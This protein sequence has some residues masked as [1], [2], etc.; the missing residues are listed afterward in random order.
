MT[1]KNIN[2]FSLADKTKLVAPDGTAL[3][4]AQILEK[5]TPFLEDMPTMEGNLATGHMGALQTELASSTFTD[6]YEGVIPTKGKNQIITWTTARQRSLAVVDADLLKL[7]NNSDI[8]LMN[9]SLSHLMGMGQDWESK[10]IYGTKDDSGRILGL[11]AT[12]DHLSTSETDIGSNVI[13]AGGTGS[14]NSSIWL[15]Y[16]GMNNAHGIY[17][18]GSVG[19]IEK[20]D[21]KT[22][23]VTAPNGVGQYEARRIL[24]KHDCGLAIPNWKSI[25]RIA[26]IDVSELAD[27]GESTYD[28]APLANLL[29]RAYNLFTRSVKAMGKPYIY[30]NRTVKTALDLIANNKPTLGINMVKDV[31]GEPVTTFWGIP[32]HTAEMILNT[33][34]RVIA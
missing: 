2:Y 27:A 1:L 17:P 20:I 19:G 25:V 15:A 32:I 26:N 12:Y 18:K 16:W 9:Q 8:A 22:E 5:S 24:F 30:C 29:I 21:Y 7:D 3:K 13:D 4:I 10:L 14:D 33:E 28:G 11:A 34:A 6:Y 31:L 23:L